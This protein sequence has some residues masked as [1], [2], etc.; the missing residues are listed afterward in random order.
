M[1]KKFSLSF[2]G[3]VII[4]LLLLMNLPFL[5]TSF[6]VRDLTIKSVM[7]EKESKLLAFTQVLDR[8]LDAG[9]FAA[10]LE[11][12]G[13]EHASR[14]EKV[15]ILNH[16]LQD[17]T[18]AVA[19]SSPGL[20][21]GYYSRDLDAIITYGPSSSFHEVIGRSIPTDHPGREVMLKGQPMIKQGSMVRGDILN[22][23]I[24]IKRDGQ[25][26]GYIWANETESDIAAQFNAIFRNLFLIM[27][28]CFI[29]TASLLFLLSRR[30]LGDIDRIVAGVRAMRFDLSKR[31]GI[32]GGELGEVAA[33]IDEMAETIGKAGEERAKT[34]AVLQKIINNVDAAIYICDPETKKLVYV[35]K[36][37]SQLRGMDDMQGGLCYE[38]LY[39]RGQPCQ[40]CSL[41]K[42]FDEL[43]RPIF[44]PMYLE[45]HDDAL[46]R[47]FFVTARLV[48]WP[49]GR[50]LYMEVATDITD[51]KALVVAEA[52]NRAQKEFLARMSHEIRTPM[53][54]VLG[55]VHLA[56]GAD[57]PPVQ[58]EYLKK[59]QA[60][61]A[62]LLGIINDILDFSRI[63]AGKLTIEK[64]SFNLRTA[65]DNIRELILPQ[66]QVKELKFSVVID[67]AVPEYVV[68]DELRL[69][70]VLLNLLGNAAKFTQNGFVA[71]D[72]RAASVDA[73]EITLYFA[74]RDSGV[75]L[76]DEQQRTLFKPFS[77][78]ES[79]T[80]RK[81]GGSGLGL[82]ISKA[83]VEL[84]GGEIH[85]SSALGRGSIFS[86]TAR[87]E[88]Y[89]GQLQEDGRLREWETVRYDGL[90][91]LLV[92]DT[93]INQEIAQAM[94]R[95]LGA[96]VDTAGN[97]EEGLRAFLAK[98]Y[99]LIVMDVRMP[100]LDGLEATRRIRAS[101]K[102][103]AATVP[104]VAMT[105]DA[106]EE[107]RRA[108]SQAGMNA[109]I[110]KPLDARNLAMTLY[111]VLRGRQVS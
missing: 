56:M 70:Q 20:G 108:S 55:M 13:A 42:L 107:D 96:A 47:D 87:L 72:I 110:T 80:S 90:T 29:L 95:E 11:E 40:S 39:D 3:R 8:Q 26:I 93:P 79:S 103:D 4:G 77:Q 102:H 61:A 58:M 65:V 38:A 24:P 105:A 15:R 27:G 1:K 68:G 73:G 82:S 54:G 88:P 104:I 67:D 59:I 28:L 45:R 97:G 64:R 109:H 94:L 33:S 60:S 69:S 37:L 86:F 48:P 98:D 83:L 78:A 44:R 52:A 22:A 53:N 74:V 49:D 46:N 100:V 10:L 50:V 66:T 19:A 57:P 14:S 99:D 9:G 23:M 7:A 6:T 92:E 71:L 111:Q 106:M 91:F 12:N 5:I 32:S 25:V 63:E 75:G 43:G 36:Y 35:N 89:K 101:G 41:E 18:D 34:L 81:F 84:M 31:I 2:Q 16:L 51:R 17:E 85:V 21:V 62:L 30:M 76:S